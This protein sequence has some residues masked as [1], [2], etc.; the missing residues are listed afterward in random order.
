VIGVPPA[1]PDIRANE[2]ATA[3]QRSELRALVKNRA[4]DPH[5]RRRFYEHVRAAGDLT[6]SAA[7]NALFYA[8]TCAPIGE[9]PDL[10][11][12][13]Q[14]EALRHLIST[15]I[16]PGPLASAF[17]RR[18]DA[19]DLTYDAADR[20]IREWLRMTMR[21]FVIAADLPRRSGWQAP[22]GYFGLM[23]ADGY[24]RC[25]RIHT[26]PATGKVIVEQITGDGPGRRRKIYGMA[27]TEVRQ[28][29]ATDPA[30]AALLFFRTRGRCAACNQELEDKAQPGYEHGFG[31]DCWTARQE[32]TIAT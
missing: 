1:V 2:P 9:M 4:V 17:R 13:D 27:A 15:R 21:T 20:W 31:F 8:R 25:Y 26:L 6:R 24:T 23:H 10:A 30:A 14:V 16:V 28:A 32:T 29:I 3:D 12:A 5:W 19:G 11:T 18:V 7:R 22:D